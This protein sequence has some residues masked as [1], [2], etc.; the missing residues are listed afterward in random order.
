MASLFERTTPQREA[1]SSGP[2]LEESERLR[3]LFRTIILEIRASRCSGIDRVSQDAELAILRR[4][5]SEPQPSFEEAI[6]LLRG[7]RERGRTS[8]DRRR[9]IQLHIIQLCSLFPSVP[10]GALIEESPAEENDDGSASILTEENGEGSHPTLI[11]ER[12]LS[13]PSGEIH[14]VARL[15]HEGREATPYFSPLSGP[16]LERQPPAERLLVRETLAIVPT[17]SVHDA[18]QIL[19]FPPQG[20]ISDHAAH[21]AYLEKVEEEGAFPRERLLQRLLRAR[22]VITTENELVRRAAAA[23]GDLMPEEIEGSELIPLTTERSAVLHS[24]IETC[25]QRTALAQDRVSCIDERL[26]LQSVLRTPNRPLAQVIDVLL[27]KLASSQIS[28]ERR[29]Q[30]RDHIARLRAAT[31]SASSFEQIPE[32]VTLERESSRDR[33]AAVLNRVFLFARSV[34]ERWVKSEERRPAFEEVLASTM[35]GV[36]EA[37]V[38]LETRYGF[39]VELIRGRA[40]D[41][42]VTTYFKALE[43]AGDDSLGFLQSFRIYVNLRAR[44]G[45]LLREEQ[46]LRSVEANKIP[47]R[48]AEQGMT[49]PEAR[50]VLGVSDDATR[51]DVEKEYV[52]RLQALD[53][54]DGAD[55]ILIAGLMRARETLLEYIEQQEAQQHQAREAADSMPA[56]EVVPSGVPPQHQTDRWYIEVLRAPARFIRYVFFGGALATGEAAGGA[57]AAIALHEFADATSNAMSDV[58]HDY[59]PRVISGPFDGV[60]DVSDLFPKYEAAPKQA[61]APA[62]QIRMVG[63]GSSL[64]GEAVSMLQE[65]G[66]K[67]TNALTSYFAHNIEAFNAVSIAAAGGVNHLPDNFPLI[68]TPIAEAMDAMVQAKAV[69][70]QTSVPSKR[71]PESSSSASVG[72]SSVERALFDNHERIVPTDTAIAPES[73]SVPAFDDEVQRINRVEDRA[74]ASELPKMKAYSDLPREGHT[75]HVMAKGEWI[76]KI[77]HLMLRENQLNWSTPRIV[78]LKNMTLAENNLSEDQAEKLPVGTKVFFNDA[79]R[80]IQAMKIAK[81]KGK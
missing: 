80:E 69:A 22:E 34:A 8:A 58:P 60:G 48:A 5:L 56:P 13:G 30:L 73:A 49:L 25:D 19:G 64:W 14:D 61:E 17:P 27:Q 47:V 46:R 65:R 77:I 74:M 15:D 23:G 37:H 33:E 71:A 26:F 57:G 43:R 79:V 76:Y 41:E 35:D 10:E 2:E 28:E 52:I 63:H 4:L 75:E 62:D 29:S 81:E 68:V 12:I 44:L 78:R 6:R 55:A 9:E 67:P 16:A 32:R 31:E 72:L 45:V 3:T 54:Q 1:L 38:E 70:H 59:S 21:V 24:L 20:E 50:N 51:D 66:L 42:L 11:P 53:L 36:L 40:T 18:R 7:E 39:S